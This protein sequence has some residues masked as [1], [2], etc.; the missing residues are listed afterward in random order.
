MKIQIL[1]LLVVVP[2]LVAATTVDAQ[3]KR[4]QK[5]LRGLG[6]SLCTLEYQT[7]CPASKKVERWRCI[8]ENMS[9]FSPGCQKKFGTKMLQGTERRYRK[10]QNEL[11]KSGSRGLSTSRTEKESTQGLASF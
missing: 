5:A 6:T 11:R 8:S 10:R 4:R 2:A 7:F 3:K 1:I 9:E